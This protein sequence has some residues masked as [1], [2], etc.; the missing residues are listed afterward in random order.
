ML[1]LVP[2]GIKTLYRV[3]VRFRKIWGLLGL[4]DPSPEVHRLPPIKTTVTAS[5][6]SFV[7]ERR[8]CVGWPLM[9]L[10]PKISEDGKAVDTCTARPGESSSIT[11]A[12]STWSF[13]QQTIDTWP[14]QH[15]TCTWAIVFNA[16]SD[17]NNKVAK[18]E[19]AIVKVKSPIYDWNWKCYVFAVNVSINW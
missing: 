15:R 12:S 16:R 8:A 7:I 2:A 9:S 17:S 19:I 11:S 6:S 4:F 13:R 14:K 3:V 10:M 5:V 1:S 18:R